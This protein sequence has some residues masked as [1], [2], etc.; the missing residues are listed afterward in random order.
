MCHNILF[1]FFFL[2]NESSWG[3]RNLEIVAEYENGAVTVVSEEFMSS[4]FVSSVD[5]WDIQGV[6]SGEEFAEW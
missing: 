5:G 2:E 6:E 1:A 4:E 3:I